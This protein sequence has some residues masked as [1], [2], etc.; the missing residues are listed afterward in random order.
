MSYSSKTK[1]LQVAKKILA[2]NYPENQ[3]VLNPELAKFLDDADERCRAAGSSLHSPEAI[4]VAIEVWESRHPDM[5]PYDF[6]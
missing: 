1:H 3:I 2:P 4:F 5:T 6:K